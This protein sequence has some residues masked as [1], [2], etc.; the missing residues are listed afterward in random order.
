[1]KDEIK[2][3][4]SILNIIKSETNNG[5]FSDVIGL[6]LTILNDIDSSSLTQELNDTI[7][8]LKVS[9]D[10]GSYPNNNFANIILLMEGKTWDWNFIFKEKAWP[11]IPIVEKAGML[12]PKSENWIYHLKNLK[13][14]DLKEENY[15]KWQNNYSLKRFILTKSI[16]EAAK[17]NNKVLTVLLTARLIGDNPLVDFDL[18]SLIIVRSSLNKIGLVN[19]ANRITQEIM[20][21]KIVN[22]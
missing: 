13:E 3:A 10:P 5:R 1:M 11:L 20:T 15:F 18:N 19:L 21:S 16:E 6:Y 14:N 22:L 8:K 12:E 9:S 4:K 2:Q 17:N 7:Q